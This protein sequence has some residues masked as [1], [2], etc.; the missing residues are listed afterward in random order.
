MVLKQ[1][2]HNKATLN[3]VC[4]NVNFKLRV[5]VTDGIDDSHQ[6]S[7]AVEYSMNDVGYEFRFDQSV[8]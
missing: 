1:N 8:E 7:D 5:L 4:E 2:K 3:S 6:L